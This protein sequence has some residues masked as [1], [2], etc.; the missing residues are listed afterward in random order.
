MSYEINANISSPTERQYEF[1]E[2]RLRR[3]P[4]LG[5]LYV[6]EVLL[7]ECQRQETIEFLIF[8]HD[9]PFERGELDESRNEILRHARRIIEKWLFQNRGR[10]SLCQWNAPIVVDFS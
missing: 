4:E 10:R 6:V 3:A 1:Q 8:Y 7:W 2:L 9:G 5:A